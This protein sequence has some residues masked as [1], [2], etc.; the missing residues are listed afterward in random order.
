MTEVEEERF[1]GALAGRLAARP[2]AGT[3]LY[4]LGQA[5]FVLESEGRRLVIDPYLSDSLAEKYRVTAFPHERMMPP[6]VGVKGLGEVDMVLT[7][8]QHTDHMDPST[9]KPLF[10]TRPTARLVAPAAAREEALKRSGI[11]EE[12]L[13]ALDAGERIE[14]LPGLFVTATRAAHET[15]ERDAA[16]HHRFLGYLIETGPFRI[17][18]S[19]DCVPFA[20]LIEEVAALAPQVTLLPVNGRRPALS[21]R[22]IAGNFSIEEAIK[23]ALAVGAGTMIAHHYGMFAFNTADPWEIDRQAAAITSP[24]VLRGRTGVAYEFG[25]R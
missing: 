3:R 15:L 5:G 9:L 17:W 12:R 19:G 1:E 10:A 22:G 2:G 13:I 21:E 4:W 18:H 23:T 16:G 24:R 8:H 11:D 6:P 25:R 7:T 20:G 14:P